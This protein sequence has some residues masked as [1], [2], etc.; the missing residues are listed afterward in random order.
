MFTYVN[1]LYSYFLSVGIS[2]L[3]QFIT[4]CLYLHFIVVST[5]SGQFTFSLSCLYSASARFTSSLNLQMCQFEHPSHTDNDSFSILLN[6]FIYILLTSNIHHLFLFMPYRY[7][8]H[9]RP[10]SLRSWG[11]SYVC[12]ASTYRIR[13]HTRNK[14]DYPV[15][16]NV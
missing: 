9:I 8:R 12:R 5:H 16:Q 1:P 6:D 3:L 4:N 10:S 11:R 7:C 13:T 14:S 2:A 15:Y